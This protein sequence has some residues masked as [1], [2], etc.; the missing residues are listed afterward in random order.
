MIPDMPDGT[1][2]QSG[3]LIDRWAAQ[4]LGRPSDQITTADVWERISQPQ[5]L[6]YHAMTNSELGGRLA[7]HLQH[8]EEHEAVELMTRAEQF[9]ADTTVREVSPA[10]DEGSDATDRY[11]AGMR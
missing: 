6:R 5:G 10:E 4:R 7:D 1:D 3:Y 9:L 2:D 8:L 11:A